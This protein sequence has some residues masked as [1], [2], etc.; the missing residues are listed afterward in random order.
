MRIRTSP[1]WG[2][3]FVL[4]ALIMCAIELLAHEQRVQWTLAALPPSVGPAQAA[5]VRS[6]LTR[7]LP[8]RILLL[9]LQLFVIV[10]MKTL[11]LSLIL[12]ALQGTLPVRLP[13]LFC[14]MVGVSGIDILEAIAPLVVG[15]PGGPFSGAA[16]PWSVAGLARID[17]HTPPGALLT[18]LNI[19]TLWYIGVLG[20][21]ISVLTNIRKRKAFLAAAVVSIVSTGSAVVLLHLLSTAY[22]FRP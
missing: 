2:A 21:G 11:L 18:S 13:H 6:V 3:A 14:I 12:H 20:W 9:P 5:D 15:I 22:G 8:G 10:W 19:F 17:P 1:S 7:D 4:L 16:A